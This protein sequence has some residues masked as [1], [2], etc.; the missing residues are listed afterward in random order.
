MLPGQGLPVVQGLLAQQAC[1]AQLVE[2]VLPQV[3]AQCQVSQLATVLA[4]AG[5][6]ASVQAWVLA[7]AVVVRAWAAAAEQLNGQVAELV[8][9]SLQ[10]MVGHMVGTRVVP[11]E[12]S[13]RVMRW[14]SVEQESQVLVAVAVATGVAKVVHNMVAVAGVLVGPL[15]TW[16]LYATLRGIA[17]EM[18]Y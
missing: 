1:W 3:L 10:L 14:V 12:H 8:V 9:G 5:A 4:M 16:F 17:T 13:Q 15:A 2:R 6:L 18:V 7:S 11:R